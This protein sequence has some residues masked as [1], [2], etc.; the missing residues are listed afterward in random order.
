MIPSS[1]HREGEKERKIND[2]DNQHVKQKI[3]TFIIGDVNK[4]RMRS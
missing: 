3:N 4:R 1:A 2:K